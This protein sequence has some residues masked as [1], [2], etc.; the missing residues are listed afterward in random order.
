[1]TNR[2]EPKANND[3]DDELLLLESIRQAMRRESTENIRFLVNTAWF[4]II[5]TP[6]LLAL[7]LWRV[8]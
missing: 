3:N 2:R 5:S 6:I 7:I 1:M 8:W 4:A